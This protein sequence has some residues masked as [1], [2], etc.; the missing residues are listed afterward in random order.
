MQITTNYRG[1]GDEAVIWLADNRC[2]HCVHHDSCDGGYRVRP[3]KESDGWRCHG[4][5]SRYW[6]DGVAEWKAVG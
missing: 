3:L 2:P 6:E 1:E 5:R 4:Y